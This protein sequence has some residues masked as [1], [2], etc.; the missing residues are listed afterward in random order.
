M[1]FLIFLSTISLPFPLIAENPLATYFSH[2]YIIFNFPL[3]SICSDLFLI[4]HR[5]R[6]NFKLIAAE[7][8]YCFSF[9]CAD[10][11]F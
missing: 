6:D 10:S 5:G 7:N 8:I 1:K 9:L 3:Y 11:F 4:I 2:N